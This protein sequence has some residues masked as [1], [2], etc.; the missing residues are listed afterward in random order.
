MTKICLMLIMLVFLFRGLAECSVL[1]EANNACLPKDASESISRGIVPEGLSALRV[2]A[3][4]KTHK[5]GIHSVSDIHGTPDYKILLNIDGE[6]LK[7][8]GQLHEENSEPKKLSDPETGDGIRYVFQE[9]LRLK[10]G[11][12]SIVVTLQNDDI[13]VHKTMTLEAGSMN[14]LVLEPIYRAVPGKKRLGLYGTPS[15]TEGL[16]GFALLLNGRTLD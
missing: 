15:F 6:V 9:N 10:A 11:H 3:S 12:H 5:P 8:S 16:K 14:N 2:T 13:E 1:F 4:I 7:L